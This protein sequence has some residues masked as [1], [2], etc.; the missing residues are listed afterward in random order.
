L[1]EL[2]QYENFANNSNHQ[3]NHI[4]FNSYEPDRHSNYSQNILN[5]NSSYYKINNINNFNYI[6][7]QSSS[8][9]SHIER[10]RQRQQHRLRLPEK[11][12]PND[13]ME[14][15][16]AVERSQLVNNNH[17]ANGRN[18]SS[19]TAMPSH[20]IDDDEEQHNANPIHRSQHFT[21]VSF[22]NGFFSSRNNGDIF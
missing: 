3:L 12:L 19:N 4:N 7:N 9:S 14:R 11:K 1:Y 5:Y 15:E 22:A 10:E 6:K 8:P 20:N 16:P 2:K 21:Q 18:F 17:D 13:K